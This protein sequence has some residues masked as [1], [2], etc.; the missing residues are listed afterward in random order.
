MEWLL[1]G[2]A[3]MHPLSKSLIL[4]L[5]FTLFGAAAVAQA[6]PGHDHADLPTLIRHP[7]ASWE[8]VLGSAACGL[9]L[10]GLAYLATRR[11][12]MPALVRWS[13]LSALAI[14]VTL[15]GPV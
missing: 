15:L 7:F 13:G 6:H 8:H 10:A 9:V 12:A 4:A 11:V 1:L 5:Y 3:G 2:Y 14:A